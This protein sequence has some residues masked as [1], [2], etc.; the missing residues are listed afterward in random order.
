M[1]HLAAHSGTGQQENSNTTVGGALWWPCSAPPPREMGRN[2]GDKVMLAWKIN[3]LGVHGS[4]ENSRK[5]RSGP[6]AVVVSEEGVAVVDAAVFCILGH[7]GVL[8]GVHGREGHLYDVLSLLLLAAAFEWGS[9]AA[10]A[11]GRG[12]GAGHGVFHERR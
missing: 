4:Q 6:M 1:L 12:A 11:C 7:G 9:G 10:V 3:F 5:R 8:D 2:R